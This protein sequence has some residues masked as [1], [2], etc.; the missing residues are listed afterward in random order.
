MA[1]LSPLL[2]AFLLGAGAAA[3]LASC[4]GGGDAK[5]LPGTTADQI[6]SNLDRVDELVAEEDCIGAEDAVAEVAAEVE[7]LEGVDLKLKAALQEGTGRLSEVVSSCD[8]ETTSEETEPSLESNVEAEELE[9]EEKPKKDKPEKDEKEPKEEPS[10]AEGPALPPQSN[11][12]GE[13]KGKGGGEP[14]AETEGETEET[15]STGGVGP[16]VG[17]E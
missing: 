2:L 12:Q 8:E 6:E 1:R 9:D 15:P 16:G 17:V 14:P 10:E 4:G 11:G 5:L 7:E 13:E 3:A